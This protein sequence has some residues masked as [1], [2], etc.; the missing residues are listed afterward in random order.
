MQHRFHRDPFEGDVLFFF[1]RC[2][3]RAEMLYWDR[4]SF[5]IVRKRLEKGTFDPWRPESDGAHHIEIDRAARDAARGNRRE[6][7]EVPP[8]LRAL[9]AFLR[10]ECGAPR[11]LPWA[12]GR[13]RQSRAAAQTSHRAAAQ[14]RGVGS[15]RPGRSTVAR[16]VLPGRPPNGRVWL[17]D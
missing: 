2:R 9:R 13:A 10:G 12:G 3:D 4:N 6:E 14:S 1:K 8:P 17:P 7:G 5:W 11:E 15:R 16:C